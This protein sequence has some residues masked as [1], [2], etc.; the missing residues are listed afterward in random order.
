MGHD[1]LVAAE[2]GTNFGSS[3]ACPALA[4]L[5]A[6]PPCLPR[7]TH[8]RGPAPGKAG[9]PRALSP[10]VSLAPRVPSPAVLWTRGH[11]RLG[12]ELKGAGT[13]LQA[14][15]STGVASSRSQ[16]VVIDRIGQNLQG[17]SRLRC[18]LPSFT[19]KL[20]G[21][22]PWRAWAYASMPGWRC[23]VAGRISSVPVWLYSAP[24]HI[25][26]VP[27]PALTCRK[28]LPSV[29]GSTIVC[30]YSHPYTATHSVPIQPPLGQAQAR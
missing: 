10:R 28:W 17:I 23:S 12:N 15:V 21:G 4:L 13:P 20:T 22:I 1:E 9:T 3:C 30:L 6:A 14:R 25:S 19:S 18:F 2:S 5:L 27:G 7:G 16:G 8:L 26:S 24:G 29:P 11:L